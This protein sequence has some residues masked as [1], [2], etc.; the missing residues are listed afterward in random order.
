M[1]ELAT[2]NIRTVPRNLHV[3]VNPRDLHLLSTDFSQQVQIHEEGIALLGTAIG[4]D[5]YLTTFLNNKLQQIAMLL[6]GESDP[7]TV[8]KIPNSQFLS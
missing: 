7:V 8:I 3:L 6:G 4:S 2:I 1:E 5:N